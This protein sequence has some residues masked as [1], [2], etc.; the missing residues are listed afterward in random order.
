MSKLFRCSKGHLNHDADVSD[1]CE[2][3]EMLG[4]IKVYEAMIERSCMDCGALVNEIQG[5][6][7]CGGRPASHGSDRCTSCDVQ[8]AA[9]E[10]ADELAAQARATDL[11]QT[12]I[13]I[14]LTPCR[15]AA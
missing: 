15:G 3:V 12:L 4:G 14:A 8:L 6:A 2:P 5:C 10:A 13:S 11:R 1:V 9:E 7:D